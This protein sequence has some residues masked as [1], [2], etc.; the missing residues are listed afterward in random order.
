MS[1]KWVN[2]L[3]LYWTI[4]SFGVQTKKSVHSLTP[5]SGT[6][7]YTERTPFKVTGIVQQECMYADA[8]PTRAEQTALGL[9]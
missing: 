6:Q 5:K 4:Q 7:A 3:N 8:I 2:L 1:E 9:R